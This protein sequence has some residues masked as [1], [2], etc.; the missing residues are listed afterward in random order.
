MLGAVIAGGVVVA[1]IVKKAK[2]KKKA[3]S[4]EGK[5]SKKGLLSRLFKRKSKEAVQ[6]QA[7]EETIESV[8]PIA[9]ESAEN[10]A[11]I[12]PPAAPQTDVE[13]LK[14]LENNFRFDARNFDIISTPQGKK[15]YL[16]WLNQKEIFAFMTENGKNIDGTPLT[17]EAL[18]QTAEKIAKLDAAAEKQYGHKIFPAPNADFAVTL[19]DENGATITDHRNIIFCGSEETSFKAHFASQTEVLRDGN[20]EPTILQL[21][22]ENQSPIIVSSTFI[23]AFNEGC[24]DI[25]KGYADYIKSGNSKC[26]AHFIFGEN[27]ARFKDTKV[28]EN[29]EDLKIF[30]AESFSKIFAAEKEQDET[31]GTEE[32]PQTNPQTKL[33][34]WLNGSGTSRQTAPTYTEGMEK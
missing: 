7:Q 32:A 13:F 3:K 5:K 2:S 28:C 24:K 33:D 9:P 21:D 25:I 30:L 14:S 4:A 6:E 31:L 16:S 27:D 1:K 12:A 20:Q 15:L 19:T 29:K 10:P 8:S 11:E 34:S 23:G 18:E 17:T 22:L 26:T